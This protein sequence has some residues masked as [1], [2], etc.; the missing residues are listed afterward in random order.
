ML[1][2][3]DT[4]TPIVCYT[5]TT[6]VTARTGQHETEKM[7]RER[8]YWP[9]DGPLYCE[10][11]RSDNDKLQRHIVKRDP[12]SLGLS[13]EDTEAEALNRQECC[14]PMCQ[15]SWTSSVSRMSKKRP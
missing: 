8:L 14:D 12:Q 7:I 15:A 4:K 6:D 2:S 13:W 11:T 10:S 9:L 3:T 1:L 5:I